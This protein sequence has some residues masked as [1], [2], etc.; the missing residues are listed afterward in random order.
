[1]AKE[2]IGLYYDKRRSK[3]WV[4]RWFGENNERGRPRRYCQ[5]FA[6]KRDAVTFQS[7]K[8]AK[9]DTG[10]QRDKLKVTLEELC[11]KFLESRKHSLRKASLDRY[12]LTI[13]Q[14]N[15]YFGS[16]CQIRRIRRQDA[17]MFVATRK[18][19]HPDHKRKPKKL[20]AGA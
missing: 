12:E 20:S 8:Q 2:K 1:M 19:I 18:I 7:A 16:T 3:P 9:L 10:G 4:V 6:R 14:L 11:S 13:S 5:A 17:E 15:E